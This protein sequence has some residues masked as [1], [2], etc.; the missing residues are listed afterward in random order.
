MSLQVSFVRSRWLIL[1]LVISGLGLPRLS[2]QDS[3]AKDAAEKVEKQDKP[4]GKEAFDYELIKLFTDSL[5]Q[6]E[7]NYVKE[8][9]RRELLEAA[10][11]G[12]L[13]K[14]DPYSQYIPP[15]ELERFRSS[16][17]NEFGGI[18]ITVSVESGDLTVTSPIFRTPAFNAGIRGGDIILEIEGKPTKGV[19]LDEAV[20]MM[21]GKI[22]TTVKIKVHHAADNKVAELNV[23]REMIRVDS[24]LGDHRKEDFTWDYFLGENEAER[25]KKIGYI[26]ITNFGRHTADE[27]RTVLN[28][29]TAAG[30]NGLVLDL[31]FNP[32]GLLSVGI[33]V[34]D[35]FVEEG[36]IVSTAGRNN[37]ERVWKAK[38][39][40]TFSDVPMVVLVNHYS[41][42]ASEIVSACLQDHNRAVV[43]GERSWGK[44]S[45]Q[46]IVE[47]EQGKSAIKL[48]TAGYLRP[49]GK[50]I[51]RHEG[52]KE[53]EEWGVKPDEGF[54]VK[55]SK[56]DDSRWLE[57]RR[58]R[59]VIRV[60]KPRPP[61]AQEEPSEP[62]VDLPLKKAQEYLVEKAAKI[63]ADKQA[64]AK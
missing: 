61:M 3:P 62:F 54:E 36:K 40:G 58:Q 37:P 12:M 56:D 31:R 30:M 45:V 11:K 20:K 4:E 38:K 16:V 44:G 46:N 47:L 1:V 39:D 5:D 52:A 51:H 10:I 57:D 34:C 27:L 29:L 28:E 32:G 63:V 9:D 64:A 33:E 19:T 13:T 2:A 25:E 14:L 60:A 15:S 7:R 41:A 21:K 22:G 17:E 23:K 26:R 49:S 8:I 43:I 48:T 6:V 42:S 35:L 18:G 55:T 24:V 59:D 50:N 53:S